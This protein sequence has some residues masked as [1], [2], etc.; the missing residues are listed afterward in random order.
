[1]ADLE[2]VL[3]T[4]AN[5]CAN[6]VY[7][8]GLS[9]PIALSAPALI[10]AGPPQA[11]QLDNDIAALASGTGGHIHISVVAGEEE[12][13]TPGYLQMVQEAP[14]LAPSP[15]LNLSARSL[16]VSGAPGPAQLLSYRLNGKL[17][18]LPIQA[19]L[20]PVTAAQALLAISPGFSLTGQTLQAP[21]AASLSQ[22][23]VASLGTLVNEVRRQTREV[24]VQIYSD[25]PA[26]RREV[27]DLL[28][29]ALAPVRF[30]H[31]TD[32][33]FGRLI[34]RRTVLV[35]TA[36]TAELWRR[37]IAFLVTFATTLTET[38]TPV[39]EVDIAVSTPVGATSV[40]LLSLTET[41]PT[42]PSSS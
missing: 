5:L 15:A 22:P 29:R 36:E 17:V 40:P 16:T 6:A 7:P 26:R 28:E 18:S 30:L 4:L 27:G 12:Q 38:I 39:L 11:A 41:T 19:G 24:V 35:D 37:D 13:P 10:Y 9:G 20:G 42:C 34:Y 33:S 3:Q 1:M 32:T 21:A 31:F 8:Q 23:N 14:R 25:S 2:E